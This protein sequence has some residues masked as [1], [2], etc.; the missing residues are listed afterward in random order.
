MSISPSDTL[1]I[2]I[3]RDVERVK[4]IGKR[5]SFC[6]IAINGNAALQLRSEMKGNTILIGCGKVPNLFSSKMS[7]HNPSYNPPS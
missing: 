3:D 2:V 1:R 4:Y 5:M 7:V 6:E